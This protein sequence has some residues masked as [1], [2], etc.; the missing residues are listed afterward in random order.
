MNAQEAIAK[1]KSEKTEF[2]GHIVS[3]HNYRH[4]VNAQLQTMC[5]QG[6]LSPSDFWKALKIT[7]ETMHQSADLTSMDFDALNA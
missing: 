1:I 2:M 7:K 4:E 5:E 6:R 3:L